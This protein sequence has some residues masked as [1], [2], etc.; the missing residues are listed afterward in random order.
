MTDKARIN[1][2]TQ[3]G[4]RS[5][6]LN[7]SG[8]GGGIFQSVTPAAR[9]KGQVFIRS[10]TDDLGF[11]FSYASLTISKEKIEVLWAGEDKLILPLMWR[12]RIDFTFNVPVSYFI[13]V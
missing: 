2:K 7:H 11:I 8:G 6:A 12:R 3:N 9:K 4:A 1:N 10:R 5:H 13:V